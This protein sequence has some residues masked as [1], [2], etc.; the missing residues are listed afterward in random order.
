MKGQHKFADSR[1]GVIGVTMAITIAVLVGFLAFGLDAGYIFAKRGD[2][3]KAADIAALAG[4]RAL[5]AY[6]DDLTEVAVVAVDYGRGNLGSHDDPTNALTASDVS[7]Y[8]DGAPN[9]VSPNQVEV[10]VRRTASRGNPLSLFFANVF[11]ISETNVG[12][13]ARV[14]AQQVCSSECIKPFSVPDLFTWDDIDG[15]GEVDVN[16]PAEFDS[17]TIIGYSRTYNHGD[18][19]VLKVGN[20]QDVVAPGHFFAVDLPPLNVGTP[21]PGASEYRLNIASCNGSNQYPVSVGDQLQLEPGNMVGPTKQG[22]NDLFAQ[23]PNAH[24]DGTQ[25]VNSDYTP[26]LSS[27]RVAVIAFY[28]PTNPPVSGRNFVT[29]NN[30]GALFIESI[31]G[32]YVYG[33]F[34][35]TVVYDPNPVPGNC[36]LYQLKFVRDSS[37]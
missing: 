6:P 32:G 10:T 9:T 24:W 18:R 37:R 27:P 16:V 25:I 17:I 14:E 35:E 31:S 23:D 20:P 4:G 29:V 36:A 7:F 11:G 12:A 33:I 30:L 3:Q 28:D 21:V 19:I 5:V 1:S 13:T 34:L 2:L 22:V 15:D 26:E 8:L